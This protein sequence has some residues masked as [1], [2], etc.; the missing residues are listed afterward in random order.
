MN[1]KMDVMRMTELAVKVSRTHLVSFFTS[2]LQQTSL[3]TPGIRVAF[4]S[5]R[6]R[7]PWLFSVRRSFRRKGHGVDTCKTRTLNAI[8]D[9]TLYVHYGDNLKSERSISQE[10]LQS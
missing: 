10:R 5:S 8:G 2:A 1:F 3:Q 6:I 9:L 4:L 7:L